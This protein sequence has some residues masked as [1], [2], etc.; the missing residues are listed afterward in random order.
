MRPRRAR[1]ARRARRGPRAVLTTARTL[2]PFPDSF[3]TRFRYVEDFLQTSSVGANFNVWQWR[4]NSLYD[5]NVSGGGHQPR[6]FD[7]LCGAAAP[8]SKYRVFAFT[9]RVSC[10]TYDSATGTQRDSM[11][12]CEPT[13]GATIPG[14]TIEDVLEHPRAKYKM[15]AE[16]APTVVLKG[17]V[18][19]P[20]LAG[21]TRA[22]YMADSD[23]YAANYNSSPGEDMY[24]NTYSFVTD[25]TTG[26]T[27]KTHWTIEFTYFAQLFDTVQLSQS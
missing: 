4:M 14:S 3:I 21:R 6:G 12:I 19:L 11:F 8:Y 7:Q 22:Q 25:T 10:T 27:V 18:S 20:K 2:A 13:N 26:N 17:H 5:P 16:N 9:Y 24:L 23:L 15:Q 1:R